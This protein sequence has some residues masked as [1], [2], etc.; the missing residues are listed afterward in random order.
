MDKQKC[1]GSPW[2]CS[3]CPYVW[4]A[5]DLVLGPEGEVVDMEYKYKRMVRRF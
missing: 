5:V 1:G 4:Y 2:P 3:E